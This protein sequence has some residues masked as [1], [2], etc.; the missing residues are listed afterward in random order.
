MSVDPE[1]VRAVLRLR[2]MAPSGLNPPQIEVVDR[3]QTLSDDGPIAE[4]DIDIWGASMGLT[5]DDRDPDD[6]RETVAEFKQWADE[7]GYTLRPAFEWRS[8]ASKDG[9]EGQHGRVVTP[10]I[11]L[12][13]YTEEG[14]Q[15]VYPHIDGNDVRTIHD[16]IE[17]LES[18]GSDAEQSADEQSKR[19][20]VPLQ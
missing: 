5:Q 9:I 12:A 11:T 13:V 1:T 4:L 2:T 17:A 18:L 19:V 20:A 3:L 16:G 6:I 14:L 15:A 10:L 8:A 7:Q